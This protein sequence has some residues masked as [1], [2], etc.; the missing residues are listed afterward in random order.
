MEATKEDILAARR[1][2]YALF[3]SIFGSDP[4]QE[5][6]E[7]WRSPVTAEAAELL[8]TED[9]AA[10]TSSLDG[11]DIEQLRRGYMRLFVGP[12]KLPV[13]PWESA[14]VGNE[15]IL[16][17]RPTLEVRRIYRAHGFTPAQGESVADDH[18]SL[19]MGFLALLAAKTQEAAESGDEAVLDQALSASRD[20][21]QNHLGA[22]IGLYAASM[23]S[24]DGFYALAAQAASSFVESDLKRLETL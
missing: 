2:L 20:F 18:L 11:T 7:L 10:L 21:L 16:F 24:E 6:V 9:V 23:A 1:Y 17:Q 19:E 12:N 4:T 5:I 22:W 14:I 13:L 3:Q 15:R 8:Q